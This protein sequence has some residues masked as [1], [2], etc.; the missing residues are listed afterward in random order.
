MR[1]S[2]FEPTTFTFAPSSAMKKPDQPPLPAPAYLRLP[3]AARIEDRTMDSPNR[4]QRALRKYEADEHVIDG[5]GDGLAM[6]SPFGP[7]I[8]R[9][10]VEPGL[11]EALNAF[12]DEHIHPGEGREF[13]L[14][15]A[16]A[17]EPGRNGGASL[18]CELHD[19]LSRF[20]SASE[21]SAPVRVSIDRIWIVSQY[22]RTPSP[23]HFHSG[24]L[25][26]ILYLKAPPPSS[27]SELSK[28]YVGGRQA[29]FV[30]FMT[31]GKQSFSK[32]IISF[33]PDVG[34]LYIF[35]AWLLHGA[36]P[37]LGPGERR[38]LSFNATV[39]IGG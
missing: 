39:A 17:R 5:L 23:I 3:W 7:M 31:A 29:G 36:E 18:L 11:I 30:N 6:L 19:A 10:M 32:S 12:A 1:R 9:R 16:V 14:P 22:E 28:T 20:V 33:P 8:G 15:A 24:D 21:R 27:P 34:T 37:F 2:K 25:S 4:K 26:G 38:S 13:L 35:P